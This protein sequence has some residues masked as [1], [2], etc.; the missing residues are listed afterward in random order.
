MAKCVNLGKIVIES[1]VLFCKLK[2][3]SRFGSFDLSIFWVCQYEEEKVSGF[4]RRER[5][6][7]IR[8]KRERIRKERD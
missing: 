7:E 5:E 4:D 8:G 1:L 2:R 3:F 6:S